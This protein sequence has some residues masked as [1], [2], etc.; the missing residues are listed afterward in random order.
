MAEKKSKWQA[1][2]KKRLKAAEEGHKVCTPVPDDITDDD[3][4]SATGADKVTRHGKIVCVVKRD[5]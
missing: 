1:H 4:K 5:K 2:L 3:V